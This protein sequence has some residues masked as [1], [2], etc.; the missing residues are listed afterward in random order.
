MR[1]F[2]EVSLGKWLWRFGLEKDAL[3]RK[4]I[5]VKYGC[6]WGGWCSNFVFGPYGISLWKNISLDG[7]PYLVTFCM[8]LVIGFGEDGLWR[9]VG[10]GG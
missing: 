3:W 10:G 4:V 9:E 7:L 8:I 2:N 1:L 5:E 6:R